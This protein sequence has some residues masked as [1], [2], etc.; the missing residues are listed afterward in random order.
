MFYY[1]AAS[2]DCHPEYVAYLMNK[3][4]LSVKSVNEILGQME[5]ESRLLY[6]RDYI[7]QLYISYQENVVDD[8]KAISELKE[9]LENRTILL[10]GPGLNILKQ[11]DKITKFINERNP[12]IISVNMI[13]E[14]IAP[15]YVFL[16]NA[17]RYVQMATA[18]SQRGRKYKIIATSNVTETN[19]QFDYV[20]NYSELL[21][22]QAEI[23]DNSF[24]M[25]L[26]V[27]LRLKKKL[28]YLAG[29]D[30]YFGQHKKNYLYAN[31]E[32][33]FDKAQAGRLNRYVADVLRKMEPELKTVFVTDSLYLSDF[34]ET[35]LKAGEGK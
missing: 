29:F 21:D 30:G 15:D 24:V 5:G 12:I 18:L 1:L 27:M 8:N 6:N 4:T 33:K 32:Y 19:K 31:M 34:G 35:K 3:R 22:R 20:L 9:A 14:E 2:N 10:L 26:K 11:R 25:L 28:V 16:S 17:K 23:I 13:V 7:E